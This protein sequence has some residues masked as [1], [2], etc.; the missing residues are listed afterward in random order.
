[1]SRTTENLITLCDRLAAHQGVMHWAISMRVFGK[2]DFFAN[3]KSG[4]RRGCHTET[5]ERTFKW[6]SDN[7]PADLEWPQDIPR[8]PLSNTERKAS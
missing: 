8:P 7:W 5:A 1:M 6:F 4:K 2:G 3:L